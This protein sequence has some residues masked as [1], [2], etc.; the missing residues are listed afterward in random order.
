M[1]A[2]SYFPTFPVCVYLE[3]LGFFGGSMRLF[4]IGDMI[5]NLA[6]VTSI[7]WIEDTNTLFLYYGFDHA[8]DNQTAYDEFKGKNAK[9]AWMRL[10]DLAEKDTP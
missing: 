7:S 10:C 3:F 6:L 4:Q 5:V 1:N 8:D 2:L 9:D